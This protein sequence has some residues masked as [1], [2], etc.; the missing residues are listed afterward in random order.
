MLYKQLC[1]LPFPLN[2][3][4]HSEDLQVPPSVRFCSKA[5]T[6]SPADRL[7]PSSRR[8]RSDGETDTRQTATSIYQHGL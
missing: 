8:I 3:F 2:L 6:G 5:A 7:T 1:I 4:I